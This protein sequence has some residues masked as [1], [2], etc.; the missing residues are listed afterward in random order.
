MS[1]LARARQNQLQSLEALSGPSTAVNMQPKWRPPSSANCSTIGAAYN[2]Q[3]S[4]IGA[5]W[6]PENRLRH[7]EVLERDC[8]SCL[9]SVRG[10]IAGLREAMGLEDET[11]AEG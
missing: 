4:L 9:S 11:E 10:L 5:R 8:A 2:H 6:S 1:S 7:L 3:L